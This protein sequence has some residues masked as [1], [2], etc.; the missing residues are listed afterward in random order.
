MRRLRPVCYSGYE[1]GAFSS[2][3]TAMTAAVVFFLV[4]APAYTLSDK[5]K[6]KKH[7]LTGK[8]FVEEGAYEAAVVELEASYE[9]NPVSIVLYNLGLCHDQLHRYAEAFKYYQRFLD[10]SEGKYQK[11][12][13]K[14]SVR[15]E[16][17]NGFIGSLE[18]NVNMKGAEVIIDDKLAGHTPLEAMLL[19]SGEHDIAVRKTGYLT[20][21]KKFTVISGET[22]QLMFDLEAAVVTVKQKEEKDPVEP[23]KKKEKKKK[24]SPAAFAVFA[25]LTGAAA[26][27]LTVTGALALKKNNEVK[28]MYEDES[29][30]QSIRDERDRLALSTDVLIGVAAA[31]AVTTLVLYFFT[32]FK[33]EKKAMVTITPSLQGRGVSLGLGAEF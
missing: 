8:A 23:V 22:T 17:I 32:D 11:I 18:L 13:K 30:L 19:E 14:V 27:S 20:V 7:F 25:G 9:L 24:L 31:S 1:M 6:A 5:Q 12:R 10:E 2:V 4:S 33:K 21:E 29:G 16:A 15:I 28:G 3:Y 26:L